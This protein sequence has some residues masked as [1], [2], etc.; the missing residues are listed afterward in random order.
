M[1]YNDVYKQSDIFK[2]IV[3]IYIGL[4]KTING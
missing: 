2:I 3:K 1:L 4:F